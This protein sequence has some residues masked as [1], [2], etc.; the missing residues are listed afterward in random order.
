MS[1]CRAQLMCPRR[2]PGW[3]YRGCYRKSRRRA[4]RFRRLPAGREQR[5]AGGPAADLPG[6][7]TFCQ[8]AIVDR[9]CSSADQQRLAPCDRAGQGRILFSRQVTPEA[10]QFSRHYLGIAYVACKRNWTDVSTRELTPLSPVR[11]EWPEG[12][13]MNSVLDPCI[14][15][16]HH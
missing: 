9:H 7:Q 14:R 16:S 11:R 8:I 6:S 1:C 4:R 13:P 5:P 10:I 15:V 2:Q 3:W 12:G